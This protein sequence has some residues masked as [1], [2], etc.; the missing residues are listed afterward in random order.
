[1]DKTSGYLELFRTNADFRNLYAARIISLLGDWFNLLALLVLLREMGGISASAF[2]GILIFKALPALVVSPTAG[3]LA[4][5][6]DRLKI[7]WVSDLVRALIVLGMLSMVWFPSLYVLYGLVVLQSAAGSFFEPAR[8]ATLPQIVSDRELTA[9]NAIGAASWSMMLTIGAA[10]GGV[11]TAILGWQWAL[12]LDAATYLVSIVFILRIKPL[13]RP[14][15]AKTAHADLLGFRAF[16]E[17]VVYVWHRPRVAT[18]ALAK[19]CWSLAASTTLL[20]TLMGELVFPLGGNAVLGVTA[21]YVFRGIGTGVGPIVSRMIADER[22]RRME[23]LIG[24]SFLGG[25]VAYSIVAV[26]PVIAIALCA[27]VLGHIGGA[28][29]WVFST[30]RLQQIVP[31]EIMGRVFATEQAVFTLMMALC[32]G[33]QG[34]CVDWEWMGP[35]GLAHAVSVG[36]I[37]MTCAWALRGVILGYAH[38]EST[39]T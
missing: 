25:A 17:G 2:G 8:S 26:A 15:P 18:L 20:L 7:M 36:L 28:T 10:L 24:V 1:M 31:N 9:A 6:M 27:V 34:I 22:A 4:D 19:G 35:R 32:T 11:F 5:R 23:I 39:L 30:V 14:Q 3:A 12:V 16:R 29:V 37:V 38:E 21:F 33:L 13:P